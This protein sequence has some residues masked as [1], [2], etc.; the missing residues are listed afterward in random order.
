[1]A[2]RPAPPKPRCVF[3]RTCGPLGWS[4]FLMSLSHGAQCP[5]QAWGC[6]QAKSLSPS[7]Q[8]PDVPFPPTAYEQNIKIKIATP[9]I[10][11]RAPPHHRH[12]VRTPS[13][14]L[15]LGLLTTWAFLHRS[16]HHLTPYLWIWSGTVSPIQAAT[17][18]LLSLLAA[19][20]PPWRAAIRATD[21]ISQLG[22]PLKHFWCR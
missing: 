7:S 21:G 19:L 13:N 1:M 3:G 11:Q 6:P 22:S 14:L 18:R 16:S 8:G 17:L 2:A 4:V 15:F 10:H 5:I 12:N 20:C 9:K